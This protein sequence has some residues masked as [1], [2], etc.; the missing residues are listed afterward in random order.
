MVTRPGRGGDASSHA[1]RGAW[2]QARPAIEW[3]TA[4]FMTSCSVPR[5]WL[6][7]G[8]A[9]RGEGRTAKTPP[10]LPSGKQR[11]PG[12]PALAKPRVPH[13]CPE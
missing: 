12:S 11:G 1:E 7:W 8:S 10:E 2:C 6:A 3:A 9:D 4:D 13:C 5:P